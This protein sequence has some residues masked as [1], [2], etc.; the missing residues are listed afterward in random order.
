MGNNTSKRHKSYTDY[1]KQGDSIITKRIQEDERRREMQH[2]KDFT[3]NRTNDFERF[4]AS[5]SEKVSARQESSLTTGEI[6]SHPKPSRLSP[7]EGNAPPS[8]PYAEPH[9]AAPEELKDLLSSR[10]GEFPSFPSGTDRAAKR[11]FEKRS[12]KT[13]FDVRIKR[14]KDARGDDSKRTSEKGEQNT[15][16]KKK[17][18][19]ARSQKNETEKEV[20]KEKP[21]DQDDAVGKYHRKSKREEDALKKKLEDALKKK[22]GDTKQ[23]P[24]KATNTPLSKKRSKRERTFEERLVS[25]KKLKKIEKKEV[26]I[27]RD[28][29]EKKILAAVAKPPERVLHKFSNEVKKSNLDDNEGGN[30]LARGTG[31]GAEGLK[32]TRQHAI[33]VQKRAP[34]RLQRLNEKKRRRV[35]RIDYLHQKDQLLKDDAFK[36]KSLFKKFLKRRQMK[37][38]IYKKYQTRIRDRIMRQLQATAKKALQVVLRKVKWFLAII[39]GIILLMMVLFGGMFAGGAV[40]NFGGGHT[41]VSSYRSSKPALIRADGEMK[42]KIQHLLYEAAHLEEMHPGYDYYRVNIE[43]GIN[44]KVD[45]HQLLAYLTAKYG[46]LDLH[47]EAYDELEEILKEIYDIKREEEERTVSETKYYDE[48]GREVNWS[49]WDPRTGTSKDESYTERGFIFSIKKKKEPMEVFKKR[50]EAL[51]HPDERKKHFAT[52]LRYKGN[53]PELTGEGIYEGEK[54]AKWKKD[55]RKVVGGN[56]QPWE[57]GFTG[58]QSNTA[59]KGQCVWYVKERLMQ[60][61]GIDILEDR[62]GDGRDI[63]RNAE[64]HQD[65]FPGWN[66]NNPIKAGGIVSWQDGDFGHVAF[67]E[68]VSPTGTVTISEMNVH[69]EW[70]HSTRSFSIQELRSQAEICSPP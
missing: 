66:R 58:H 1:T 67:V 33:R 52:V 30:V 70:V 2:Q 20:Q 17:E 40:L 7:T 23:T 32:Q 25:D 26:K 16:K 10:P 50:L 31:A 38:Q 24:Q 59:E 18:S 53:M 64:S 60:T 35:A 29:K 27:K 47:S 37:A 51:D 9:G 56:F 54:R 19:K 61:K 69:G 13:H 46:K 42:Q 43:K 14:E 6:S 62:Y 21:P 39:A 45:T 63:A 12:G 68:N 36:K 5:R 65:K 3:E 57:E 8:I 48:S 34:K 44:L 55:G 41:A 49:S 15:E 4:T 28:V 22:L 11:V